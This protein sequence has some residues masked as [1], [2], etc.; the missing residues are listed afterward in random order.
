MSN[1]TIK[2]SNEDI[3]SLKLIFS[4]LAADISKKEMR[5]MSSTKKY[6]PRLKA[7]AS[8]LSQVDPSFLTTHLNIEA[9]QKEE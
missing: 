9:L 7:I 3:N 5:E 6:P 4:F 8:I 1:K 2:L